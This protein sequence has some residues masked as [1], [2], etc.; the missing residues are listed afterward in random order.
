MKAK[1]LTIAGSDSGGGAG[2]QADIK[3]FQERDVFGMSAITA[4]TAQNT[5]GVHGVYPQTLEAIEKQIDVVL[6][7][8]GADSVKTGML[9]SKEIIELVSRLL[10]DYKVENIVVDPVMIAKGGAKLLQDEAIEALKKHLL[11]QA[12]VITPNLPEAC[13]ILGWSDINSTEAMEEAALE[14]YKLG[15]KNVVVKGGHLNHEQSIDILFDGKTYSYYTNNRINTKHTHG[16][17]CT[18][19]AAITAELAKGNSVSEAVSTAKSFITSAISE[20]LAIGKG[21]GPT[22]HGAYRKELTR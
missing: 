7:D 5:L 13:A 16:T 9:F 6:S 11:P 20:G 1:A 15:A 18:F 4:I 12:T 22:N 2:I 3:T 19:A 17:G 10:K 8:I 14:L 21:I